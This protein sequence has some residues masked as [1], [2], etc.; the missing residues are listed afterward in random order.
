MKIG[1]AS[2]D[3]AVGFE[4]RKSAAESDSGDGSTSFGSGKNCRG[5]RAATK[6]SLGRSSRAGRDAIPDPSFAGVWAA[7]GPLACGVQV[8][9]ILPVGGCSE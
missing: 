6:S 4:K 3:K 9:V 1:A 7:D 5:G 2:R 8:N